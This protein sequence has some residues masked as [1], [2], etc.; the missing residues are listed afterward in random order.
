MVS[1]ELVFE[2]FH[3]IFQAEL[4]LLESYFLELF[5]F[6]KI[7]FLDQIIEALRILRVFVRQ[8]AELIV[9]GKK[10]IAYLS[11]NSVNLRRESKM[12]TLA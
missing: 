8:A 10:L 2:A 11:C 3:L 1:P 9:A 12:Q 7:F 4:Q 6:R 5:V